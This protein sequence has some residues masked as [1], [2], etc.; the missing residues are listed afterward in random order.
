MRRYIEGIISKAYSHYGSLAF[1]EEP[2]GK[3]R[4]FAL[5]DSIT[6]TI[7]QPLHAL[8]FKTLNTQLLECDGTFDQNASF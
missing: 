6:Q 4:I 2:A 8:L 5:V 7:L 3:L 1:K